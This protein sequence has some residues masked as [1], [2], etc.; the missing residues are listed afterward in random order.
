MSNNF[1]SLFSKIVVER[2]VGVAVQNKQADT[3]KNRD[4][5]QKEKKVK[6]FFI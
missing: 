3:N 4:G 6:F 1:S 5:K 2:R